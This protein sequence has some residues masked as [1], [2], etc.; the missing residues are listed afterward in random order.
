MI[1]RLINSLRIWKQEIGGFY[2]LSSNIEKTGMGV[3]VAFGLS[4]AF[5]ICVFIANL[6]G[7]ILWI[8]FTP[9]R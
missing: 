2:I 5:V 9:I 3:K 4:L 6:A 7:G 8:L 1:R